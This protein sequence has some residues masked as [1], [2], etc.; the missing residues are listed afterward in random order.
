MGLVT[1]EEKLSMETIGN[2]AVVEKF[3]IC[4]Q[5]VLD[6]IADPNT[7]ADERTITITTKVKPDKDKKI[8][9]ISVKSA[10]KLGSEEPVVVAAIFGVDRAGKGEARELVHQQQQ[11]EFS[12]NVTSME[13][14]QSDK[15]D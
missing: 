4:L 9:E 13:D 7:T 8:L 12:D 11:F 5:Q 14:R 10:T 15:G 1:S 3:G 2:G 6:N